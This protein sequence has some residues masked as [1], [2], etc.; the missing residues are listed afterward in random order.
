MM[1]MIVPGDQDIAIVV[2]AQPVVF[3]RTVHPVCL[4]SSAEFPWVG[5]TGLALG[6]GRHS[7]G[8]NSQATHL[9]MVD[10][11]VLIMMIM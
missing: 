3:S 1:I 5:K 2:L 6:W 10:L 7:V 4:P 11:E 9:R 8:D